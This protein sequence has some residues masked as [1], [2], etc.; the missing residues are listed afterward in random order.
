LSESEFNILIRVNAEQARS[1]IASMRA[2]LASLSRTLRESNAVSPV[3]A[4]T[5]ARA[6]SATTAIAGTTAATR[7]YATAS[8][9]A[10]VASGSLFSEAA[11]LRM[12]KTG[13]EMQWTG[14]QLSTNFTAPIMLAAG[15]TVKWELANEKAFT[16]FQKFYGDTGQSAETL[17]A[18]IGGAFTR[19]N[20]TVDTFSSHMSALGQNFEALSN[21]F[22]VAQKDVIG[23][24][25]T[26][27]A[28]GS[29]GVALS[30]AVQLTLETMSVGG[31]NAA[32]AAKGLISIQAQYGLSADGLTSAIQD[33]N[34]QQKITALELPD[35]IT[36]FQRAG[37]TARTAGIDIDHLG[38]LITA[39]VPNAA[40]A[41]SAGDGLKTMIERIAQP[42][43]T[44]SAYL[45][46]MGID[47]NSIGYISKPVTQR[48]EEIAGAFQKLSG[49]QQ[50]DLGAKLSGLYQV[51]KFDTLMR[52]V[53]LSLDET[54]R[55][56]SDYGK[57]LDTLKDKAQAQATWQNELERQLKS[58]PQMFKQVMVSI[59]NTLSDAIIP[60]I[61]WLLYMAQSFE[62]I[63]A[64]F[65]HLN[66]SVQKFILFAALLIAAV[67]PLVVI[68]YSFN[69]LISE[70]GTIINR[71]YSLITGPFRLAMRLMGIGAKESAAT[72]KE[73]NLS[74]AR[75]FERVAKVATAS[76]DEVKKAE[77]RKANA[78]QE[79]ARRM[80]ATATTFTTDTLRKTAQYGQDLV[81]M[82][83]VMG[84]EQ[85]LV[86]DEGYYKQRGIIQT[87]YRNRAIDQAAANA[88]LLTEQEAAQ[89]AQLVSL[90]VF[91][92][93]K[94]QIIAMAGSAEA[95]AV[96]SAMGAED[97]GVTAALAA[98][99]EAIAAGE[100]ALVG[101]VAT[102]QLA[103]AEA[104][105]TGQTAQV[106]AVAAA[107]LAMEEAVVAGGAAMVETSRGCRAARNDRWCPSGGCGRHYEPVLDCHCCR[108]CDPGY[109]PRPDQGRH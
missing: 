72:T 19:G 88:T 38:A 28:A 17:N 102:G 12:R 85:A 61:P 86:T 50:I 2:E 32:D 25:E 91:E 67:G 39:L 45:K 101:E 58:N 21:H 89:S 74:Q 106:E 37:G 6:A 10:E 82:Y 1:Q 100:G 63:V 14:R 90:Q 40:T 71:V 83:R 103:Q 15:E 73:A 35:M 20:T 49:Q 92:D 41:S 7:A 69:I 95:V 26:F 11:L 29:S 5:G 93:L 81:G 23:I 54:T 52:D 105:A 31:Q 59:Q 8:R 96:A 43:A 4:E 48:I 30:K 9:E 62:K 36:A 98:Q 76:A 18:E 109:V 75:S 57:S 34:A 108:C 97:L 68:F 80:G 42:T 78:A 13:S 94:A 16:N 3:S 27:A 84:D 33:L 77:V 107:Q 22:G 55:A 64:A 99:A 56:N 87:F 70:M 51:S 47:V 24:A 53:A 65:G 66:P 44:A 104:V 46:Q 60:L 79:A